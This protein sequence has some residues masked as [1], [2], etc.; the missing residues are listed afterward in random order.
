MRESLT[1][2]RSTIIV[3]IILLI[4]MQFAVL[5]LDVDEEASSSA[6]DDFSFGDICGATGGA[7]DQLNPSTDGTPAAKEWIEG[8]YTFEMISTS[9]IGLTMEWAMHEFNDSKVGGLNAL[10]PS[11]PSAA[12]EQFTQNGL[13]ADYLRNFFGTSVTGGETVDEMI[14]SQTESAVSD[15]LNSGF[16][17]IANLDVEYLERGT[18]GS[19]DHC[20]NDAETD[21]FSEGAYA[22]DPYNPPIC[23]SISATIDLAT[24]K[25]QLADSADLDLERSYQGLLTMGSEISTPFTIFGMVGHKNVFEIEPPSYATIGAVSGTDNAP[26]SLQSRSDGSYSYDVGRWTIDNRAASNNDS[27]LEEDVTLSIA[28]RTTSTI[29]VSIDTVNDTAVDISVVLDMSNEDAATL[30]VSIELMYID[31]TTMEE[32]GISMVDNSSGASIPWVTADGIRMAE[33]NGLV[34]MSNFTDNFPVDAIA[35]GISGIVGEGKVEMDTPE[36][37]TI[38]GVGG[39]DFHHIAGSTCGES[40]PPSDDHDRYCVQ[41]QNAMSGTYPVLLESSSNQFQ[42]SLLDMA[43]SYID[44]DDLG[45]DLDVITN[46]DLQTILN[47]GLSI[48]TDMGAGFVTDMIPE[49]L[50]P[51]N[52]E[53]RLILPDWVDTA[54]GTG[55]VVFT[56]SNSV[57]DIAGTNPYDWRNPILD[58]ENTVC[59]ANK[60]SCATFEVEL[61][62]SRFALH[63]WSQEAEMDFSGTATFKLYRMGLPDNARD[64]L[65]NEDA[66][67]DMP[68]VPADLIRL[69][70]DIGGRMSEPYNTTVP[71]MDDDMYLAFTRQGITDFAANLGGVMTDAIHEAGNE[72]TKDSGNKVDFSQIEVVS[73]VGDLLPPES[74]NVGDSKPIELTIEIKQT[75]LKVAYEGGSKMSITTSSMRS[76]MIPF[77][78]SLSGIL[79]ENGIA[80]NVK[81]D[82]SGFVVDDNGQPFVFDMEGADFGEEAVDIIP[83]MTFSLILPAG[84]EFGTFE[85][86]NGRSTIIDSDGRQKVSYTMPESGQTDTLSISFVIGWAFL[87]QEMWGYGGVSLGFMALMWRRRKR[88]RAKK[89]DRLEDEFANKNRSKISE[90]QFAAMGG[91][92]DEAGEAGAPPAPGAGFGGDLGGGDDFFNDASWNK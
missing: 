53:V 29:P 38:A 80:A 9:Q 78:E 84:L 55:E 31:S 22:E 43:S 18:L 32:W 44:L 86:S 59:Q 3:I 81:T 33:A 64:A 76:P 24:S 1:S 21:A 10:F 87:M 54:D 30:D 23:I 41:G 14:L 69:I 40:D 11:L 8:D 85:S 89:L 79:G 36:W 42:F 57:L 82:S 2:G 60:M 61:D 73:K 45:F 91:W 51:T 28:R 34:D 88:K 68:V 19:A 67:L 92:G 65:A 39:L 47:A 12:A 66:T 13:P 25:F 75:T 20:S 90:R 74:T 70:I 72:M 50:P 46:A 77:I 17:D 83:A 35:D 63:E 62:V 52:V 4:S 27:T 37:R 58:G 71:L 5:T 48:E 15:L 56:D 6:R 16:G 7:C 49:D 26:G